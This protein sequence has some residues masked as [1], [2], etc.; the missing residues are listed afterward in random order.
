MRRA[1]LLSPEPPYP[2]AGGGAL[3]TA[4]V[5]HYLAQ[6][7]QV[8]LVVFRQPGAH[9]PAGEI[10]PGLVRRT[11]IIDL[12]PTRR[13]DVARRV[14]NVRRL[15]RGVPPLIDRFAGFD[16]QIERLIEGN[17]YEVG[18]I[19]HFWCAAYGDVISRVCE[20]TVLDLHNVESVWHERNAAAESGSI[21]L[22][23]RAFASAA[24]R[25]ER[26]WLPNFSEILTASEHDRIVVLGMVPEARVKV[27]P[28]A[29]PLPPRF[30]AAREEAIAFSGNLEYHPNISAV[31]F[32]CREVWPRLRERW[33]RLVWRLIGK[34][35]QAVMEWTTGD[36]RI[37]TTGPV[38]DAVAE[39]A[40]A[41]IAV[42]PILA[43]S[44]TRLK[45]LEAWGAGVPVVATPMGAEGLPVDDGRHLLLAEGGEAFAAA[46]SRLLESPDLCA[47]LAQA[48]RELLERRFTWEKAWESLNL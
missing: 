16:T 47:Q 40:R 43:G 39:L 44:G 9:D 48:G 22:A 10:P 12:P 38:A 46:V 26:R 3:R 29:I 4:S 20:R 37:E 13:G 35:P 18:V 6:R 8:D 5:L 15:V 17:Q 41:R 45:I 11:F 2:L 7:Y 1:L 30:A 25:L 28:N 36:A 24:H 34:N 27:Y 32:F 23:H 21:R 19:E 14:R 33:P 31:R 42:V